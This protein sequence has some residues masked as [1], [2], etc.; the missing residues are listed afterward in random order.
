MT[1]DRLRLTALALLALLV[2]APP[3]L[4]AHTEAAAPAGAAVAAG[5]AA[6]EPRVETASSDIELLGIVQGTR[7]TVYLDRFATNEPIDGA[8]LSVERG[9]DSAKAQAL[10]DGTYRFELPWL[11]SPG[12][13]AL[14]FTVITPDLSDLLA[15]TLMIPGS[16]EAVHS[17][18]PGVWARTLGRSTELFGLTG[19]IGVLSGLALALF[20]FVWWR[21]RRLQAGA[22][23][24]MI[25]LGVGMEHPA[26]AHEAAPAAAGANPRQ[27]SRLADGSVFVPMPAQ[28]ALGLRTRISE[29]TSVPMT[30]EM[31]GAV[32]AD[33]AA[34]GQ[35]QA[36][37]A[38]R[39]EPPPGGLPY[40]GQRV[41][42]GALLAWIVPTVGVIERA[43][44]QAQLADL[45][46][47]LE[48]ARARSAR[49]D[50]LVG[51]I[52]QRDIDAARTDALA[53]VQRR[54]AVAGGLAG[55]V[56]LTAPVSGVIGT[57]S[58][59]A[60][61]VV[62]ARDLLFRVVDPSRLMVEALAYDR[63]GATG[64]TG[65][66]ALA[67]DGR[68][69]ALTWVGSAGQL[70]EQALPLLFR[71]SSADTTLVVGERLQV[72][73]TTRRTTTGIVL[74]A[75][76]L[77]RAA[78]GESVVWTQVS[79]ERFEPV[80]VTAKPLDASRI[81][82]VAGLAPAQRVV[83]EAASLLAQIR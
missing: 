45:D 68:T 34:S 12:E 67:S 27:P 66:S 54:T 77:T 18:G 80:R 11:A 6:L 17:H 40:A 58:A 53:L 52:P 50:Q 16:D 49:Y 14:Q 32:V 70:R 61:Q 36:P 55:R 33:P 74:P 76:S 73:A 63:A 56:A 19:T 3:V 30:F 38:G 48:V 42:R 57:A 8:T 37:I 72:I 10:G 47:Q 26:L 83:T 5:A 21:R 23:L 7:L 31:P 24:L 4:R 1:F 15:A 13:Y 51:S 2:S 59:A 22:L 9:T 35:V 25:A 43:T 71:V 65:G 82:V 79:A 44:Q 81:V 75:T 60:G 46:A 39:L 41:A 64:I 29:S 28:R 20:A 62:D 78:N 69:V